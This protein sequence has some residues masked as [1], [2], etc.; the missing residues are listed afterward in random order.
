MEPVGELADGRRLAGAVH[1]HDQ[2]HRG[3]AAHVDELVIGVG[4]TQHRRHH[5]GQRLE[6]LLAR[7][8]GALRGALLELLD[9][10]HGRVDAHVGEDERLLD[11]L[12]DSLVEPV[13]EDGAEVVAQRGARLAEVV[14]EA[15]EETGALALLLDGHRR[16]GLGRDALERF[17]PLHLVHLVRRRLRRRRRAR[18]HGYRRRPRAGR[19]SLASR[20]SASWPPA[21]ARRPPRPRSPV[22]PCARSRPVR[23]RRAPSSPRRARRPPPWCASGG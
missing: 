19:L 22:P 14:A 5:V 23:R 4:R 9:D 13:E 6:E 18:H 1:A 12:P 11:L 17:V 7:L 2:D 21:P 10:L 16:L 15:P 3:V 20:P 8:D